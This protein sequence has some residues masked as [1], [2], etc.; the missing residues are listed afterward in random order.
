[1]DSEQPDG[2]ADVGRH[3]ES[4][5]TD[6][7][8]IR[9]TQVLFRWVMIVIIAIYAGVALLFIVF[10]VLAAVFGTDTSEPFHYEVSRT[11]ESSGEA[12]VSY[13]DPE[14]GERVSSDVVLPWESD[15]WQVESEV[16]LFLTATDADEEAIVCAVV[17]D[18]GRTDDV[19]EVEADGCPCT[20]RIG[21][22]DPFD[23]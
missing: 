7:H 22:R 1:M 13:L 6:L 16:D 4:I 15:S 21:E 3:L 9:R 14:T 2:G 11:D 19:I 10:G 23:D 17:T 20:V 8:Q 5:A 12:S 18:R